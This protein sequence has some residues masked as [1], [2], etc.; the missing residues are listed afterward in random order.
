MMRRSV[1][2]LVVIALLA[3]TVGPA[4][5]AFVQVTVTG[6]VEF[7]TITLP[8]LVD[9]NPGDPATLTFVVD[10]D[11]FTNSSSF[12]VRG[13]HIDQVSFDLDL[14]GISVGLLDP[15]PA[16]STPYF[17]V[18]DNDPAVDG[19]FTSTSIDFPLGVPLEEDGVFG[20]FLNNYLVTYDGATLDSLDILDALG[21]YDFTGLTTF[22]WTVDD[23]PFSAL[24]IVFSQMVIELVVFDEDGDGVP[25]DQDVCAGTV[26]PEGVPTVRLGTNRW[27]LVDEDGVFDTTA[28][29]GQGPGF[30]F[31]IFHTGGCSCEQII[32]ELH[33]GQ[34]H[35]K[36]GCSNG[37]MLTWIQI[38]AGVDDN[39]APLAGRRF[40]R[41]K[42]GDRL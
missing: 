2:A 11:I 35:T 39:G 32:E 27:A 42:Q 3:V 33:L 13:Y 22:N 41:T 29:N 25:D 9:V 16:G 28:P 17:S 7:N 19:F 36:F 30:E 21:T 26:I 18:R 10:S 31:D 6:T 1:F 40:G 34:G 15:F 23:G 8:P 5:A 12:P 4:R 20:P 14:G 37:A 24:S 38:V